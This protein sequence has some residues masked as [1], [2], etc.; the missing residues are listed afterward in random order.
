MHVEEED[1]SAVP[2]PCLDGLGDD[3]SDGGEEVQL[4]AMEALATN[5]KNS[6]KEINGEREEKGMA[7]T[8]KWRGGRRDARARPGEGPPRFIPEGGEQVEERTWRA[9]LHR[10]LPAPFSL[11][12]QRKEKDRVGLGA[13]VRAGVV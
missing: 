13:A 10:S 8:W 3:R 4:T 2:F 7:A 5:E 6:E 11:S 1:A 12:V 9:S